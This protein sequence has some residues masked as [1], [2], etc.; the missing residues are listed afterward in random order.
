MDQAQLIKQLQQA[1][2]L[3]TAQ[4][5]FI[6]GTCQ[7]APTAICVSLHKYRA[8]LLAANIRSNTLCGVDLSKPRLP[9]KLR[10]EQCNCTR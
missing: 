3:M 5:D 2:E 1:E 10:Q 4:S 6:D 9:D 8:R 7:A